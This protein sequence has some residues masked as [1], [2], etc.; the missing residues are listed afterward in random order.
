[1]GKLSVIFAGSGNFGTI[2]LE[3]LIKENHIRIPFVVTGQDKQSGRGLK[4]LPNEIKLLA[5]KNKLIVHQP[6]LIEDLKQKLMQVK[7]DFLLVVS[8]GEIIKEEV[9]EIPKYGAINI[10]PS[11]LPKYRGASPIQEAILQ[12]DS[13]TG[14]TWI[15]MN[16]KMDSGGIIVSIK[17]G[18]A[19]DDDFPSLS[20]KLSNVA[21]Q[22][23]PLVL[24][25]FAAKPKVTP[26]DEQM[27][28]YCRK[29]K[30]E[31]GVLD[32]NKETAEQIVRK[33]RAYNPWPGCTFL[34]N[35]KKLKVL[36]AETIEQKISAPEILITKDFQMIIGTSKDAISII[37]VQPESKRR[38]RV[39]DF[40][41]GVKSLPGNS[42]P[43]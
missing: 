1:M 32:F 17:V 11:L 10:H 40:L 39:Q 12:G 36:D 14:V 38:M 13:I 8:Y 4:E 25:N 23:T 31:D 18:I 26:Q 3:K 42:N 2:I 22:H 9:L 16:K 33:V 41:R 35:G 30:K 24:R 19:A 21:A 29:I 34:W 27:A 7:P 5:L 15:K 37:T 28:T 43:Q 6:V 20:Q